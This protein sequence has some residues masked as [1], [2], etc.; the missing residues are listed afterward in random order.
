[1]AEKR[2]GSQGTSHHRADGGFRNPWPGARPHGFGD[3]LKWV[4]RR[5]PRSAQ[6]AKSQA[7]SLVRVSPNFPTPR[8]ANDVLIITWVGHTSFLVQLGGKNI[9]LDP[10]WSDRASPVP[11]A[12]P[13]RW[14]PPAIPFDAL[15]P[16]DLVVLSHDHYD[17]LDLRTVRRL[18]RTAPQAQWIAPLKVGAWLR[19][20]GAN[21]VAEL[22]WWQSTTL[23]NLT[24]T[25]TPAQHFSG[26]S[27]TNRDGTLWCGWTLRSA[28]HALL[29]AGDTGRHPEFELITRQLGPFDAAILPIGAYEPRW[30]MQP[31]HMAPEETV[32]AYTDIL[33]GN[34]NA[35]PCTFVASHWGTFKLTDEPLD[36]PPT[37]TRAA[38]TTLGLPTADL[39]IPHHGETRTWQPRDMRA[40]G[41]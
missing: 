10:V 28:T 2:C 8:A 25:C 38:W 23:D 14:V 26:R 4:I 20:R 13:R 22:D 3:F 17:H 39:W 11:F 35:R 29:F 41:A 31:V 40:K 24:I 33:T 32:S 12:G 21:V 30:F 15:P 27:L 9:L 16:I 5:P 37:L 7:K 36:E 18:I 19:K 34:A 6:S 1:M